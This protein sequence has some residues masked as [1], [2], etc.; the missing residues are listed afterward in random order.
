MTLFLQQVIAGLAAGA[1]YAAVALSLALI[2]R[3]IK[4]INFAQGEMALF[5]TYIAWQLHAWGAPMVLAALAAVLCGFALGALV[6]ATVMTH[7]E[8]KSDLALVV[9]TLGLFLAFNGL[10]SVIWG[11]HTKTMPSTLPGGVVR[12]GD[13]SISVTSIATLVAVGLCVAGLSLAFKRTRL[14]MS[15]RAVASNPESASLLGI[16]TA[17]VHIVGWGLAAAFGSLAG[18]FVAP[19]LFLQPE[20]M[21][22]VLIY[23]F[24][25]LALGG[26][27]SIFGAVVASLFVGVAENLAGAYVPGVGNDLKILVPLALIVVVLLVRPSGLFGTKEVVR[28]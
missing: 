12:I 11:G 8:G 28:V 25:G 27:D 3:S 2:Y 6:Q 7:F 1:V 4:H 23:A 15:I 16:D 21:F 26:L 22:D 17:R 13:V 14:G 19:K 5:T 24:A 20:M 10:S 9:A 18:L